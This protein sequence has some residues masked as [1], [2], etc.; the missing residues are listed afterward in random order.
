MGLERWT[1]RHNHYLNCRF[2]TLLYYSDKN[3]GNTKKKKKKKTKTWDVTHTQ[4]S[5]TSIGRSAH[6]N[7]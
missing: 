7:I 1:S 4:M 2:S 5:T 3:S 6:I